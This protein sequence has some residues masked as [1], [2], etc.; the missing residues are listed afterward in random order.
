MCVTSWGDRCSIGILVAIR[1]FQ[2]DGRKRSGDVERDAVLLGQHRDGVGADLVGDVAVGGDAVRAHDHRVNLA[3]AHDGA[4][5]V[6]G[7]QVVG[8][9]SFINSHAVR[10]EP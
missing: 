9:P 10:R 2:I 4:R 5:H 3:L 6:V 8:M 7:D 1:S